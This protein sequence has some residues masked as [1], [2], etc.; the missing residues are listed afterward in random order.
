MTGNPAANSAAGPT[1]RLARHPAPIEAISQNHRYRNRECPLKLLIGSVV[2]MI[3][4]SAML[5]GCTS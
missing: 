3:D 4:G 1:D 5:L 2:Q